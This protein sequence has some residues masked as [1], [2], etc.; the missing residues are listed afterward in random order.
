MAGAAGALGWFWGAHGHYSEGRR[1]LEEA[2]AQDD[3]ASMAARVK[4]LDRLS[5]L[6]SDQD[7]DRAEALAQEGLKL[8]EQ[9]GLGG[10]VAAEFLRTLGWIAMTRG[11]YADEGGIRGKPQAKP[12]CG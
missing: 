9:A 8:S 5:A 11:D 12:R 4:A 1:W 2:L 3:R 6:V 10:A 7:L